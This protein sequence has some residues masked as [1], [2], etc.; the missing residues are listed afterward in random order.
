MA[1]IDRFQIGSQCNNVSCMQRFMQLCE[2]FSSVK[3]PSV[4]A[5]FRYCWLRDE[6]LH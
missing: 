3:G 2:D 4:V 1:P 6:G 5:G